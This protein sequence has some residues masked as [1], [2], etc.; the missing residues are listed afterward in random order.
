MRTRLDSHAT[1]PQAPNRSEFIARDFIES[2]EPLQRAAEIIAG[3]QSSG[4]FLELPGETDGVSYSDPREQPMP[5]EKLA[6]PRYQGA[7]GVCRLGCS[8]AG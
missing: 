8:G 5:A 6:G 4:T 1:I 3:E 7:R 2:P